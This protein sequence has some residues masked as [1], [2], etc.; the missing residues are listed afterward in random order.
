MIKL[1]NI[2]KEISFNEGIVKVPENMLSKSKEVHKYISNNLDNL[3]NKSP[4]SYNNPYIDPKFKNYFQFKDLKNQ[5]LNISIGL[6]NDLDDAGAG[7]MDTV[8]DV[9]LINLAFF[10]PKDLEDFE[11]LIEHELV[12]AMDP[13][14]RDVKI[15]TNL[16]SKK[17]AELTGSQFNLSKV[18]GSKS[19]FEKNLDKY[20]KSP[21]EFDA[22]TAPLVNKIQ[23]NIKKAPDYK[24]TIIDMLSD[25]KTN[26]IDDILN[27][28][29][30]SKLPYFF[31]KREWDEKNYESIFNDYRNDLSKIK[32]W[33]TKPTLYK[34][35]LKRLFS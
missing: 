13:K 11:D 5:D 23:T 19:E 7:R 6:Y 26:S 18:P 32:T 8:N 2:L 4:K 20:V 31:T 24:K 14:V 16:Y 12:H 25:I 35:F 22:F 10:N 9:L 28:D 29:K 1:I 33:S 27:N 30:Y 17:G 15:F 3:K 21:W 34:R